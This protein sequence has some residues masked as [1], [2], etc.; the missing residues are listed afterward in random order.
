MISPW[1]IGFLV[2][3]LGP[4]LASFILS[5]TKWDMLRPPR[6][7]GLGNYMDMATDGILWQSVYNTIYYTLAVVPLGILITLLMSLALNTEIPG[8]RYYRTLYYLPS[9][10]PAVANALLWIVL[11]QPEFGVVNWVLQQVGLPKQLWLLD[12]RLSKPSLIIMAL[13]LSGGGIPVMLAGLQGI[14]TEIYEAARID[15]GGRWSTF[16]RITLPLLSPVLFFQLITGFIG[17]FQVFTAAFI[18]TNGGP[19]NSTLFYVLYLY[20]RS[21]QDF[22]MGLACAMAWSLFLLILV[23][24]VVQFLLAR[25][26]VYY[27]A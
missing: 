26:W 5:L 6:W 12:P 13:S 4:F 2:L 14:S 11:L 7:V 8:T 22:K 25:R 24:T 23:F 18:A 21:F 17:S 27:E 9:I 1:M 15:G 20:F 19:R 10:T 3:G 16:F